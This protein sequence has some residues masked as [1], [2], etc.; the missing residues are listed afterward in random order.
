MFKQLV[1]AGALTLGLGG[2]TAFAQ[3][4]AGADEADPVSAAFNAATPAMLHGPA[5]IT[6]RDQATMDLPEGFVFI[7]QKEAGVILDAM[8]NSVDDQLVG[9]IVAPEASGFSVIDYI[10]SGYIKDEEAKDWKVDEMLDSIK[11]G[12]AQQNEV[13]KERGLPEMEIVGWVQKPD[14]DAA[15]HRLVWSLSSRH[16]GAGPGEA[17]GINYNTYALGREGYI[18]LNLVTSLA[19][20][21]KEKPAAQ[22]LL[23]GIHYND[24]KRYGDFNPTT[25]KVAE[26]G[27]A[28][29]VGGVAAKKLGLLAMIGLFLAKAWKLVLIG[30]VGLGALF[31]KLTGRG[32]QA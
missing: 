32:E 28:A 16:R 24:G 31:R 15:S 17:Q 9:M 20:I 25:D 27:I 21:E 10:P 1:L 6:L 3:E 23:A 12:T 26:Y 2:H 18:N 11:E 7:P 29:L 14:Y 8:G 30:I 22:K 5:K 19:D 13:R 4:T